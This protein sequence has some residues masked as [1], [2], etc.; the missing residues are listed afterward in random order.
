MNIDDEK[1]IELFENVAI[2]KTEIKSCATKTDISD[3]RKDLG[4]VTDKKIEKHEEK[5]HSTSFRIRVDQ[6]T[7]RFNRVGRVVIIGWPWCVR[8]ILYR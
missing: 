4:L 6:K 7:D 3:L 1:M 2:V 8:S 5:F